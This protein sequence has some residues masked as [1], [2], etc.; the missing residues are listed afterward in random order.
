MPAEKTRG[1]RGL[2]KPPGL[3]ESCLYREEPEPGREQRVRMED[4]KEK[5]EGSH[6]RG[7]EG[8]RSSKWN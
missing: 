3:L 7:A 5:G 4:V 6:S 2:G 8:T 1:G